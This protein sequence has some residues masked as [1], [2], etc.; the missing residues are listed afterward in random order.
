MNCTE[1]SLTSRPQGAILILYT[2]TLR[3]RWLGRQVA[4]Y[5]ILRH[6]HQIL[7]YVHTE[8]MMCN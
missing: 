7:N 8:G 6:Q 5:F 3:L 4:H 1:N 2:Q